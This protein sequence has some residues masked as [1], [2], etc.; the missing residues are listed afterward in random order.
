MLASEEGRR[1][2]V[3]ETVRVNKEMVVK[4]RNFFSPPSD[5]CSEILTF[6]FVVR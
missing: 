3:S 4:R 6:F 5:I 2:W 1:W